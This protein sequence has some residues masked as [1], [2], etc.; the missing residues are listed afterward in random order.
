MFCRRLLRGSPARE[1]RDGGSW[2]AVRPAS[3]EAGYVRRPGRAVWF[4]PTW[5]GRIACCGSS[6]L[7]RGGLREAEGR[8]VWFV[9]P[10]E[11]VLKAQIEFGV[12]RVLRLS[13]DQ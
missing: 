7:S 11:N 4:V 2:Q 5:G 13:R 6:R 8:A 12:F 9:P 1:S 3:H 10:V